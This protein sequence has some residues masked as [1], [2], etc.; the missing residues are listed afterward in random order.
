[1][2]YRVIRIDSHNL[3]YYLQK[4][5]PFGWRMHK[6]TFI[7]ARGVRSVRNRDLCEVVFCRD[8]TLANYNALVAL[9]R[10]AREL[11]GVLDHARSCETVPLNFQ[12]W[13]AQKKPFP[14]TAVGAILYAALFSLLISLLLGG[15]LA[16]TSLLTL[17]SVALVLLFGTATG[18]GLTFLLAS[19]VRDRAIGKEMPRVHAVL[20]KKYKHYL[21]RCEQEKAHQKEIEQKRMRLDDVLRQA[22]A[23]LEGNTDA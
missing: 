9:E 11:Q 1:M 21:A 2:E 20:Y 3:A 19:S 16:I 12:A 23:L 17:L 22:D 5:E 13:I 18:T 8:T 10:E 4:V 7:K 6:Q 15:I 14:F